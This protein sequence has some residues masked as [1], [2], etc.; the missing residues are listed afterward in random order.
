[1]HLYVS[2]QADREE[3]TQWR[4]YWAVGGG[5]TRAGGGKGAAHCGLHLLRLATPVHHRHS[6][7]PG[8]LHLFWHPVQFGRGHCEHGQWPHGLQRQQGSA[9]GESDE[10]C[11]F[12]LSEA[13]VPLCFLVRCDVCHG[14]QRWFPAISPGGSVHMGPGNSG[15]DPRLLLLGLHR[16]ADPWWLYMSKIC[17]QQVNV[18]LISSNF[19]IFI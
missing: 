14:K 19:N 7:R 12:S 16:H 10:R 1:M 9:S 11:H 8:L 18:I 17:S 6:V 5:S 13:G 4:N 3:A 15:D 2:P